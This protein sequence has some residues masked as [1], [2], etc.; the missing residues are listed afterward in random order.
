[1]LHA[2]R[3]KHLDHRIPIAGKP[4]Q[5][6]KR[7]TSMKNSPSKQLTLAGAVV[8]LVLAGAAH[9]AAAVSGASSPTATCGSWC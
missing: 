8:W 7:K 1:M 3:N 6:T 5:S 4:F 2:Y 9:A